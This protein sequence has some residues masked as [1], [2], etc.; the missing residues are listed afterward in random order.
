MAEVVV[1]GRRPPPL[2]GVTRCVQGLSEALAA[3]GVDHMVVD[4]RERAAVRATLIE[5]RALHVHN[6]SNVLRLLVVVAAQVLSGA[7]TVVFFH[8]GTLLDQLRHPL[9]QRIAKWGFRFVDGVWATN[10]SLADA[11]GDATGVTVKVVSPYSATPTAVEGRRRPNSAVLFVGNGHALYGL[12]AALAAKRDDRLVEWSWA[13]VVYGE[14]SSCAAARAR[15]ELEGC[16]VYRNL[17]AQQVAAVLGEHEVLLRPTTA[18]GDAMIVREAL[19][20]GLRV[21]ATDVVPRPEGVELFDG[22]VP[23]LIRA[24]ITRGEVSDGLGLGLPISHEILA[25]LGHRRVVS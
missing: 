20:A 2:G 22:T 1:W 7:R 10:A 12:E 5:R 14:E 16:K 4:W 21:I 9:R 15:A 6:V 11:I 25:A 23:G 18:D 3:A 17:D 13:V 24:L 19:D 8:S